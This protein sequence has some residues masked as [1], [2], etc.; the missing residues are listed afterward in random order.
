[1]R[2]QKFIVHGILFLSPLVACAE[3]AAPV[4]APAV[5]APAVNSHAVALAS[6]AIERGKKVYRMNCLQCHNADPRKAGSQGPANF[7]VSLEVLEAK[8][9]TGKYPAGYVPIRK[10]RLMP[11]MPFLKKDI[12]NLHAYL[13]S[14]PN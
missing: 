4:K 8:V 7:G 2:I 13:N 5:T 1:M 3:V 14:A 9:L 11:P 12:A 6:D 10:T